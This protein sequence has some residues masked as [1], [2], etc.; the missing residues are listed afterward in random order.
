MIP[1]WLAHATPAPPVEDSGSGMFSCVCP[2][3]YICLS[4]PLSHLGG[5]GEVLL[6][7]GDVTFEH[8]CALMCVSVP[9]CAHV[10]GHPPAVLLLLNDPCSA[11]EQG[12]SQHRD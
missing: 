2:V 11:W 1:I 5:K 8:V 10:C 12:V 4:V 6:L 3:C 9:L 7:S